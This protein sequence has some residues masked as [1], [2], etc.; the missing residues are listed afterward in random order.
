VLRE[1]AYPFGDAALDWS[2]AGFLA[3]IEEE[4]RAKALAFLRG[5]LAAGLHYADLEATLT[6]AALSHYASFG[7]ALIYLVHTGRLIARLGTA[8]E[9]P[10]LLAFVRS[11]AY[12]WRE[13]LVPEFRAY[14]DML[15]AWPRRSGQGAAPAPETFR[16]RS[17]EAA[18]KAVVEA[19]AAT[20]SPER[21]Y[22]ALL[23]AAASNL[24]QFD[25]AWQDKTDGTI[26]QNVGW[27]DF[28][29]GLTFANA[30]R[31]QCAKFPD[32]WPAGLLQIAC[33][34][35]RATE[36]TSPAETVAAWRVADRAAFEAGA[37]ARLA[38]HGEDRQILAAHLLK[39]FLA[40]REEVAAGLPPEIEAVVLAALNRFLHAPLKRK[41][42]RRT[43]HQ[44]LAFVA[45]ED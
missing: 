12:A 5:A 8:V 40:G 45:L 39:T 14:A 26:A 36:F 24:L 23:G 44:A 34:V 35:G 21:L 38:D 25:L 32:L 2:E 6:R 10:L 31:R 41:H 3:A 43:A 4:D 20:A 29:H 28:S 13:D 22:E 30:V 1:P 27:L 16:R 33:F 15:A 7:H 18:M 9:A 37:V 42:V 19:A 11:L 17:A